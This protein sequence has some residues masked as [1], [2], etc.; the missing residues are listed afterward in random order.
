MRWSGSKHGS[1]SVRA[2]RHLHGRFKESGNKQ[3]VERSILGSEGM[4]EEIERDT[5]SSG[6]RSS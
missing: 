4:I 2:L 5:G 6:R 1:I 3:V